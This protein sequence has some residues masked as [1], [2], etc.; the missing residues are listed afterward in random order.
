MHT[1][2]KYTRTGPAHMHVYMCL[3]TQSRVHIQMVG[4]G[5]VFIHQAEEQ[6]EALSRLL[7]YY[8][9]PHKQ[10]QTHTHTHKTHPALI[11]GLPTVT[12]LCLRSKEHQAVPSAV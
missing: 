5:G 8:T 6:A 9:T 7:T 3:Q 12:A 2:H 11:L 1:L 10:Q 4:Q